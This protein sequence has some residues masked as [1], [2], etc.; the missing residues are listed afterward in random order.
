M[1]FLAEALRSALPEPPPS[2]RQRGPDR[3]P[4]PFI[5]LLAYQFYAGGLETVKARK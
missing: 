2:A 5:L 3:I 1:Q 4:E